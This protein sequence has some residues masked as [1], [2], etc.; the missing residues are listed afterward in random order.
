M[1]QRYI[2][3]LINFYPYFKFRGFFEKSDS[4]FLIF[5]KSERKRRGCLC[6]RCRKRSK[7]QV[8]Q[9]NAALDEDTPED[10]GLEEGLGSACQLFNIIQKQRSKIND[11]KFEMQAPS[12][13]D[14]LKKCPIDRIALYALA[15]YESFEQD[16][17]AYRRQ[18]FMLCFSH[19][20]VEARK[21]EYLHLFADS[22]AYLHSEAQILER[23]LKGFYELAL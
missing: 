9:S 4:N 21:K 17:Q 10:D 8:I 12:F 1:N 14:E 11:G 2:A 20:V 18:R 3:D 19:I 15:E 6:F 5:G 16:D 23:S 7:I 13:L 22:I